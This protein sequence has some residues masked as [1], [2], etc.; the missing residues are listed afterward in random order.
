[1]FVRIFFAAVVFMIAM[2][3]QAQDDLDCSVHAP[4]PWW[5]IELPEENFANILTTLQD[6]GICTNVLP[7]LVDVD[8]GNDVDNPIVFTIECAALMSPMYTAEGAE[9][10]QLWWS[11]MFALTSLASNTENYEGINLLSQR[12]Y[13]AFEECAGMTWLEWQ[14]S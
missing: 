14:N 9:S 11:L 4:L 10:G 8:F 2:F 12:L 7:T 6:N 1:M 13:A 5:M 3:A